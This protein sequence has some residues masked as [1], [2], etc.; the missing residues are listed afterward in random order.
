MLHDDLLEDA[1]VVVFA[2]ADNPGQ[3]EH[4]ALAA[5]DID[6]RG[7]NG[8]SGVF[9]LRHRLELGA[10][11]FSLWIEVESI[12]AHFV[13]SFQYCVRVSMLKSSGM[14]SFSGIPYRFF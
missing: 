6:N 8:L 10:A 4:L 11:L 13:V 5:L 12:A 14:G 1:P 3:L 9:A 7:V 2:T